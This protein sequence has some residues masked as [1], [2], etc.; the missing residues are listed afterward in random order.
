MDVFVE[1]SL[2][3]VFEVQS[4]LDWL[5]TTLPRC[6]FG[7]GRKL[8]L[9]RTLEPSTP[10]VVLDKHRPAVA[11]TPSPPHTPVEHASLALTFLNSSPPDG[12]EVKKVTTFFNSELKK[13]DRLTSLAKRLGGRMIRALQTTWRERSA[14]S[15]TCRS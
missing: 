3:Q 1:D 12:T 13:P 2:P 8:S 9:L 5:L 15:R 4:R 11:P 14:P 10:I 7:R 6:T